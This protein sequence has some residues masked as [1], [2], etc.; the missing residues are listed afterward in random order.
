MVTLGI[1]NLLSRERE[2][3]SGERIGLITNPSGVNSDLTP[4]ID[5]MHETDGV[6]LRQL[7]GPEHGIRGNKQAGVKVEDSVDERTTLP[8]KSLYDDDHQLHPD[9][10][11]NLDTIVYDLQ[12]IGSRFYTLI[13]T[14]AYALQ[15]VAEAGIRMT[16][17]DRPNPIA[18]LPVRGNRIGNG[19]GSFVGDYGLPVVHGLT[20]G[21]LSRYINQEYDI[22]ANLDVVELSGWSRDMWY[23]ETDLPWVHPSP[24]MPT[25]TTATIYPGTCLFEGTNL[26]EG[27]GTTK[28]FELI[29]APWI[30]AE[31]WCA[32]L[33][34]I[35]LPG[36]GFRPA[37]FTPTFSKHERKD[38]EGVHVHI[39]DRN[40]IDP[41][42]IGITM[43]TSAFAT[44]PESDWLKMNG[45]Y[46]IDKLAG[47][48]YLRKTIDET[49]EGT[50]P[51][52]LFV[53]M[54][55]NW[56]DDETAFLDA[57]EQYTIY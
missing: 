16:V 18:P 33:N 13:Y 23:D 35:D 52:R 11:E 15:G 24:N 37:Y 51:W 10:A 1:E 4:T 40:A 3:L 21:E 9:M 41:L 26:S 46:F 22:D 32:T 28:P 53:R 50:D 34:D 39:L 36:V 54:R 49:D 31:E 44:Y 56:E 42:A 38:I 29:G 20:V 14:L 47:G 57:R 45:G 8:V 7:F 25:L 43:L 48:S 30:N 17:L 55:D 5:L 19:S 27:R 6:D 12:D 2:T